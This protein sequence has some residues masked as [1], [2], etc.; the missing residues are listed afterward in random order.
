MRNLE[1]KIA[2][3]TGASAGIGEATAY[4]LAQQGATVVL[5]ARRIEALQT[6]QTTIQAQGG[7]AIA[8]PTDISDPDQILALAQQATDQYGRVD[9]LVNN[10]GIGS[11]KFKEMN[12]EKIEQ[13]IRTNLLGVMLLTQALLPGM[14]ERR[15]GVIISIASVAGQIA[16]DSLYSASKFGLRGFSLGLRRQLRGTGIEVCLVSPGFIR[17][18]MTA[19][20]SGKLP[21]PEIVAKAIAQLAVHPRREVII[22]WHYQIFI[23][24]EQRLPGL[25][26]RVIGRGK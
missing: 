13:V 19:N 7:T 24:F 8:I 16:I 6:V 3:V 18:A 10:A 2:I 21:G 9:I 5:A 25:V 26:D 17:T 20:R 22:P 1:G 15:Q 14:L 23:W 4:Q 11:G 12:F